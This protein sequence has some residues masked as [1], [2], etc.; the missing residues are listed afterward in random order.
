MNCVKQGLVAL[1]LA[2]VASFCVPEAH[3]AD[4]IIKEDSSESRPL[5]VGILVGVGNCCNEM[6]LSPGVLVGIPLVDGGF[7]PIND[8]FYLE[9]GGWTHIGLDPSYFDVT[10]LGGVR[11]NFHLMKVWDAYGALRAGA[12]LGLPSGVDLAF[13]LNLSVG[14]TWKFSERVGLRGELG[15]G[16]NSN[17]LAVG[18]DIDF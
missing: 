17:S 8:S 12:L 10:A 14:T 7:V 5:E 2:S 1:A 13:D 15:G 16:L 4:W 11:W 3:A 6:N 9:V 18:V